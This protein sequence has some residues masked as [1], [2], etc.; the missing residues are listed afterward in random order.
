MPAAI[1]ILSFDRAADDLLASGLHADKDS[2]VMRLESVG[3]HRF[4]AYAN[5]FR[6]GSGY[7]PGTTLEMVWRIYEFDHRLRSLCFEAI[8]SIEVQVRTL[9]AYHFAHIHG[10]TGYLDQVNFP[11]FSS[12][13]SA[14]SRWEN[15]IKEAIAGDRK[16]QPNIQS[17]PPIWSIAERMDFGT[18]LS[19]FNGVHSDIRKEVANTIGQ[20]DVVLESWLRG[21][22]DPRNR[23]A[24]HHRI[25]N[26]RFEASVRI[27]RRKKFP[28]W[29]SP[30]FPDNRRMAILLTICR[31]WLNRMHP[32]NDWTERVFA[33]FDAYPE[34]PPAAMGFPANWRRHP[35]WTS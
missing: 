18:T 31:Y 12:T 8:G 11:N 27:P 21:L 23:C 6:A 33:L 10:P 5:Y 7:V 20:A 29:H 28:E 26:W 3:E 16:D 22:R 34:A 32:G 1:P 13:G 15:K 2:L 19:F 30:A 17:T 4:A 14:F 35:L 24:H 25:W 9:L